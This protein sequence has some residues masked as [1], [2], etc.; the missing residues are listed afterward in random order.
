MDVF[1]PINFNEFQEDIVMEDSLIKAKFV[2]LLNNGE[3]LDFTE[4]TNVR[5]LDDILDISEC[6]FG[7]LISLDYNKNS[8]IYIIGKEGK[9]ISNPDFKSFGYLTIPYEI[10]R[11]LN[12]AVSKYNNI[13]PSKIYLRYDDKFLIKNFGYFDKS[14]NFKFSYEGALNVRF[15]NGFNCNFRIK[16][17]TSQEIYN[18]YLS[19]LKKQILIKLKYNFNEEEKIKF[20]HKYKNLYVY[21]N[22]PKTWSA[23][24]SNKQ[25]RLNIYTTIS[26]KGPNEEKEI[27]LDNI[28]RFY[29]GF[30]YKLSLY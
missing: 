12:D 23:K 17:T 28:N 21:P 4:N 20:L 30:N 14:W 11:Y 29:Y 8:R 2:P 24:V 6:N 26:Y 19:T 7:D 9:L 13:L 1:T 5:D 18:I 25:D 15:P 22:I 16:D 3:I 10:T 27:I